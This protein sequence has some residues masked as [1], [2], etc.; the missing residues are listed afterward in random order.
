MLDPFMAG[1]FR[2][3]SM[4]TINGKTFDV[5]YEQII[6]RREGFSPITIRNK[7]EYWEVLEYTDHYGGQRWARIDESKI[8]VQEHI[9]KYS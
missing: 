8:D 9:R 5:G 2:R 3:G 1:G 6:L 4:I 7:N